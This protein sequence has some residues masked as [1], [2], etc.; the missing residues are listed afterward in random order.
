MNKNFK[1]LLI[2]MSI[3]SLSY[4][5]F[6][7]IFPLYLDYKQISLPTIGII[8]ALPTFLY[9]LSRLVAG[10]EADIHG[11]KVFYSLAFLI[12]SLVNFL[13]AIAS[14][15]WHFLF[16][17]FFEKTSTALNDAVD[18]ILIY[19]AVE[20][21]KVG[22]AFGKLKGVS[23]FLGFF[24]TSIAGFLL[25]LL[26]YSNSIVF[27]GLTL[28]IGF[29]I[30]LKF[31][32]KKFKK[33]HYDQLS[34]V[35][36]TNLTRNMKI[37]TFSRFFYDV[38]NGMVITFGIQLFL[39]K[40]FNV[41]PIYLSITLGLSTLFYSATSFFFGKL[42]DSFP[43]NKIC[44]V[45]FILVGILTILIGLLPS[46]LLVSLLWIFSGILG[47][48]A[49]ATRKMINEYARVNFRGKDTNIAATIA[50]TADFFGPL[51]TGFLG[52]IFFPLV[53]IWSG[54]FLIIAGIPLMLIKN[55]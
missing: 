54:V 11:R 19:E 36:D 9:L 45:I 6:N 48:S 25:I 2:V 53:F 28:F 51:L 38:S 29:L 10:I 32:E 4:S 30:F 5:I 43:P 17:R 21:K 49:P 12:G 3:G 16:I 35:F 47:T 52:S 44:F 50:S 14:N 42:S 15:A 1:I 40:F 20:K 39:I 22:D 34:N 23:N 41:S 31:H 26:G 33:S 37:Y 7:V 8:Y 55:S 24:G 18:H 27:C 46:V 13:Y